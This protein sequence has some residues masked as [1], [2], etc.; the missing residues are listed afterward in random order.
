[1]RAVLAVRDQ[2]E[3][4][5]EVMQRKDWLRLHQGL[6]TILLAV[7]GSWTRPMPEIFRSLVLNFLLQDRP[8]MPPLPE[9]TPV[10]MPFAV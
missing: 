9:A 10:R 8:T 3:R 5:A 6:L 7:C 1:M 4:A 2:Y